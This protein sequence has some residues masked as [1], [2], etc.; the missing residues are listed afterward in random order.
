MAFRLAALAS[1][2][3]LGFGFPFVLA[4][5]RER[6][7]SLRHR[8]GS[9]AIAGA[10]WVGILGILWGFS[11]QPIARYLESACFLLGFAS[12]L[13]GLFHLFVGL[14]LTPAVAQ[15]ACGIVVSLLVGTVF[16]FDPIL[17]AAP[18]GSHRVRANAA[19]DWNPYAVMAYSIFEEDILTRRVL[20]GT[21]LSELERSYPEWARAALW[22]LLLGFW[23]HV[24][25]LGLHALKAR[26]RGR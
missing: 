24:G 3:L 4:L 5:G 19:I 22:Y 25:F 20:Y 14:T 7:W 15:A 26:L 10:S 6:G 17:E 9:A 16:Y 23:F 12:L 1:P 13:W 18:A 2:L 11:G 8:A 21:R